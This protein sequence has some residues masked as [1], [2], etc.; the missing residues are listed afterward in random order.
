MDLKSTSNFG[1]P[2]INIIFFTEEKF[3]DVDGSGGSGGGAQAAIPPPP[4]PVN[5]HTDAA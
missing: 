2:L 5:L 1:P 4:P 3:S